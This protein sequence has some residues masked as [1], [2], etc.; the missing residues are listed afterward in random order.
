MTND[1][2]MRN[3]KLYKIEIIY[4]TASVRQIIH[5]DIKEFCETELLPVKETLNDDGSLSFDFSL[6]ENIYCESLDL[7]NRIKSDINRAKVKNGINSNDVA[8]INIV[9]NK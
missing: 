6:R 1:N 8:I 3:E 4:S 9:K 7:V 2:Y 5:D